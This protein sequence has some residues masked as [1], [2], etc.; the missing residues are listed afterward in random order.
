MK[1]KP[2]TSRKILK[3]SDILFGLLCLVGIIPGLI[4][5]SQM[6][7]PLPIHWNINNQPDSF[8]PKPFVIFGLPIIM[9]AFHLLCC[10][11]DNTKGS[12]SNPKPIQTIARLIIPVITIILESVTVMYVMDM[13]TDIGLIC[14][15]IIG[16][17]FILI[18]NYLPKTQPN[19]TFGIKL[20]WTVCNEDVWHR[21]HRLAGWITV[22]CGII[23]IIAAF[24][25][26]YYVCAA[27]IFVVIIV[28]TVYSYVISVKK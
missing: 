18:G 10:A 5:Y 1:N 19:Y 21:T 17:I 4:F 8:A 9:M 13:L 27:A 6:P 22:L 2:D 15:L 20:P 16:I 12:G 7:S 28:P 11:V 3:L 23:V 24:F 25:S 26:A 14:C